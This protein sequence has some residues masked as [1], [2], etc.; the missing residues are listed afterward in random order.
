MEN[1]IHIKFSKDKE[2]EITG[3]PA[4]IIAIPT[5]LAIG[6]LAITLARDK[7]LLIKGIEIVANGSKKLLPIA[8]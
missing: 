2:V 5:A 6:C 4:L 7:D 1:K 3:R 8:I